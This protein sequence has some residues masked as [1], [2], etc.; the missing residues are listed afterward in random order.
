MFAVG[1]GVLIKY[2]ELKAVGDNLKKI[3]EE[4]KEASN[5]A[6][7]LED[8]IGDPYGKNNLREAAEEFEDGWD[9]RR[10]KL[11]EDIEKVE[12]HVAGVLEGFEEWDT[13]TA[14]EMEPAP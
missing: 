4:L 2:A 13:D 5:R 8:A 14:S 12:Q 6:D 11:L 3:I 10:G 1:D 9:D 7:V